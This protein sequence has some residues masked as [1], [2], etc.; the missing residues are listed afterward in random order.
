MTYLDYLPAV[1]RQQ[2]D[3]FLGALLDA[4]ESVV[5]GADDPDRPG[6]EESLDGIAG[7][8]GMSGLERLFSPLPVQ[9][10]DVPDRRQAPE[11]FLDWLA[12]WVA[13]TL[14]ADVGVDTRRRLIANAV[15]LYAHRGTKA[16]LEA[17][18]AL[19]GIGAAI[20]EELDALQ[21]GVH[22]TIGV[23]TR[24]G[25]GAPHTFRVLANI[26]TFDPDVLAATI[27]R[28]RWIVEAEKP[29]HTVFELIVETPSMQIGVHST[30]GVDTMLPSRQE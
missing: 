11:E 3:G 18:L 22:A 9:A 28:I 26:P 6:L 19:Y 7:P 17:L 24:I 29:A 20:D 27:D 30:I 1:F 4:L 5:T 16:G 8:E 21:I 15:P 25:G 14:R 23:D 2:D 10:A 13:V 12:G